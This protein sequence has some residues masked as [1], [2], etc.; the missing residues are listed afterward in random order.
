MNTVSLPAS[1]YV[2][3][4]KRPELDF[5]KMKE[6]LGRIL[7]KN[8]VFFQNQNA[9]P[10]AV[11][12][13]QTAK[14]ILLLFLRKFT[15]GEVKGTTLKFTYSYLA[16]SIG[17][18]YR[19]PAEKTVYR[20]ILRFLDLPFKFLVQKNRSSLSDIGISTNCIS[21]E[22]HPSLVCFKNTANQ[23]AHDQASELIGST[24]KKF[25]P[26]KQNQRV[27]KAPD[28]LI[29]FPH[30]VREQHRATSDGLSL[31]TLFTQQFGFQQ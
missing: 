7:E 11:S 25:K 15:K 9:R 28:N 30:R 13:E 8:R 3:L 17:L 5:Q 24:V 2:A 1:H 27:A 6:T 12:M 29:P 22:L 10:L 31:N 26:L 18:G 14:Q 16:K 4:L 21:V 23:K 19:V 20:H